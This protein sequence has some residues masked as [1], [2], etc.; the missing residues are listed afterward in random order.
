MK[1]ALLQ[2]IS[3][4]LV[5]TLIIAIFPAQALAL[6]RDTLDVLNV[7]DQVSY[8]NTRESTNLTTLEMK[9]NSVYTLQLDGAI[10]SASVFDKVIESSE[11]IE[12]TVIGE[13]NVT[14]YTVD[15][16]SQYLYKCKSDVDVSKIDEVLYIS[17]NTID[18]KYVVMCYTTSGLRELCVYENDTDTAIYISENSN[19]K[20]NNFRYG[21]SISLSD[22]LIEEIFMLI[23]VGEIEKLQRTSGIQVI[24]DSDGN[25]AIEPDLNYFSW[26]SGETI[27]TMAQAPTTDTALLNDLK[28][29]FPMYTHKVLSSLSK[30]C[31]Y[32]NAYRTVWAT[33][34]RENYV[35]KSADWGTWAVGTAIA[36]IAG[37]LGVTGPVAATILTAAGI[38]ISTGQTI[39]QQATL[40]RS[41]KYRFSADRYGVVYDTTVYDDPVC[42]LWYGD[43]GEFAGGYDSSGN[44]TWIVSESPSVYDGDTSEIMTSAMDAYNSCLIMYSSNTMYPP[45]ALTY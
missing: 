45:V 44:F 12:H 14:K 31:S 23:E 16:V 35:K 32:L 24:E 3:S 29:D 25:I 10:D 37:A 26:N 38:A 5:F 27:Q 28:T 22:E 21:Q 9:R 43:S 33:E 17:Y 39:L 1:K 36:L 7:S 41:A 18:N 40:A 19:L 34:S 8:A 6:E 13:F 42:T 20:Y 11:V 15:F 4:L 2:I 30:Y